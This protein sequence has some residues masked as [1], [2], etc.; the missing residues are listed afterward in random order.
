MPSRLATTSSRGD[1]AAP[2]VGHDRVQE[3]DRAARRLVDEAAPS[4]PA[5]T[6]SSAWRTSESSVTTRMATVTPNA[7][8]VAAKAAS[9][10]ASRGAAGL[11]PAGRRSLP[12][13][14]PGRP[15]Q[16]PPEEPLA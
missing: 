1:E 6:I 10:G 3:G 11:R 4:E 12:A 8:K 9:M 2:E 14:W 16:P 15:L 13:R 5:V 7:P